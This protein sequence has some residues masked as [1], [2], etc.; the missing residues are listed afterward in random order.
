MKRNKH[1]VQPPRDK[2]KDMTIHIGSDELLKMDRAA[3]RQAQIDSGT[4]VRGGIH[5]GDKR[6][7]N[8]RDRKMNRQ[9]SRRYQ[10]G[11]DE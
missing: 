3:R 1:V 8:R 11:C 6:D 2:K 4:F 9:E 7:R 5:G 10:R